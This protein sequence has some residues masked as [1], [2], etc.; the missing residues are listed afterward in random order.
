MPY[1]S[2]RMEW[3][4]KPWG[5]IERD[6]W[7]GIVR[8]RLDVFVV[9]QDCPYSDL[10]GKDLRAW[11]VWV[12][13]ESV[14]KGGSVVGCTRVLAPGVGYAEP[15]IGRVATRR[16]KRGEGIG[17][18]LIERSI[19]VCKE[20]WPGQGIRISAQCYL[21]GWYSDLGFVAVGEPYLEDGIP[22]VQMLRS[23]VA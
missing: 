22:H 19:E 18:A 17:K 3:K 6:E 20:N 16:D 23:G 10:D 7:H 4:V 13:D 2:L 15:S 11:H 1:I 8:L 21:E 14:V 9:E 12:E 5:S